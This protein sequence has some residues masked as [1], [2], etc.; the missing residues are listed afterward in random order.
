A[1][2]ERALQD[3]QRDPDM[4]RRR[5]RPPPGPRDLAPRALH[6]GGQIDAAGGPPRALESAPGAAGGDGGA[7][8]VVARIVERIVDLQGDPGRLRDMADPRLDGRE[9]RR[10]ERDRARVPRR[11]EER[12]GALERG[13]RLHE[14]A[15]LGV[16]GAEIAEREALHAAVA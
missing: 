13:L 1:I 8:R 7:G 14:I 5:R 15:Y 6:R 10:E 4:L 12:C 2:A 11:A 16:D 3:P 9:G